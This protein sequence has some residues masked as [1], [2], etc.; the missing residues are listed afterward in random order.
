M[1][2]IPRRRQT[3]SPKWFKEHPRVK[4]LK[5]LC[6][7]VYKCCWPSPAQ[8]FSGPRPM[9]L[10]TIFYC[11]RFETSLFVAFYDSQGYGGGIRPRVHTGNTHICQSSRPKLAS[12]RP[13]IKLYTSS[14]LGLSSKHVFRCCV[15]RLHLA[16]VTQTFLYALPRN[17]CLCHNLGDVFQQ[18]VT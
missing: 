10:A 4:V 2:P 1:T 17:R 6:V 7:I 14:F 3:C 13:D 12:R 15:D 18:T 8:S 11:L 9:G 5:T 16:V